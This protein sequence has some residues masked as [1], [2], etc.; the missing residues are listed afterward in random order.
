MKQTFKLLVAAASVVS[1]IGAAGTASA[2]PVKCHATIGKTVAKYQAGLIKNLS[3]CHKSRN[4]GKIS[5][6]TLC[7]TATGADLKGGRSGARQ[8][9]LDGIAKACVAGTDDAVLAL[10]PR[11]PSPV[12]TSDN[13]GATTGIDTFTEA[14]NCLLDLSEFYVNKI[15]EEVLGYPASTALPLTKGQ[16]ACVNGQAKALAG[17]I[18]AA[19]GLTKCKAGFEGD[20]GMLGLDGSCI[21][22]TASAVNTAVNEAFAPAISDSCGAANMP[23]RSDFR[24]IGLCGETTGQLTTCAQNRVAKPLANGLLAATQEFPNDGAGN[25]TCGA[26]KADV[27]I[28]AAYGD[29][30][31]TG[32]RTDTRLDAGYTG[33]SHNVDVVDQYKGAVLLTGCN[34]DCENCSVTMDTSTATGNCRCENNPTTKCSTIGGADAA[35]GGGTC[36]CMFGPPLALSAGGT[37]TCVVNRFAGDFTGSTGVVGEYDVTTRTRALVHTGINQLQP[38]PVCTGGTSGNIGGTGTCNGGPRNGL[39]CTTNAVNPDFGA[40]SFD[41]PPDPL[42]NIS[43]AGLALAL[44]FSSGTKTVTAGIS[45]ASYCASGTCHCSVCSGDVLV[46][47]S[48][49][50]ECIAAGAG[51]CGANLGVQN[52][53]QNKCDGGPSNCV[54]DPANPGMGTC[55]AGPFDDFCSGALR[56]NGGGII[57]CDVDADCDALDSSCDGGDCGTCSVTKPR[58]CFLPTVS[59][60]GTPGIFS[61]EGV[62]A[63]CNGLT[64][65]TGVN[66]AGGLPGPGRVQLDFDFN[67]YCGTSS[68]QFNLP[69]G[70]NCP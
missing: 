55:S 10:Y 23:A 11:C 41:C 6:G 70:S 39:S 59:G 51:T 8:K 14:G 48:S 17:L 4:A 12:A 9:V 29:V 24:A 26:G 54:A 5:A 62:S 66:A 50:A 3:G 16:Q 31:G 33:F 1:I 64:G 38:C 18:K 68:T 61:S 34:A 25:L 20:G 69:A 2:D 67:V 44:Q 35:C 37:P 21:S 45:N 27:I 57:P 52:P 19:T 36:Q 56:N 13:G 32:K 46:G 15:G 7:N 43:G 22:S 42:A 28:N 58:S 30:P 49:D 65:N 63:F 60:T 40:S 53:S 47:C